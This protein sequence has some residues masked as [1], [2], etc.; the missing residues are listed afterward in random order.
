MAVEPSGD[1]DLQILLGMQSH[2]VS[3][4]RSLMTTAIGKLRYSG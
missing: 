2:G 4:V 3:A 1:D